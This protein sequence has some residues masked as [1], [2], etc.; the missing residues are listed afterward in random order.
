MSQG[1]SDPAANFSQIY[2]EP[3]FVSTGYN[4]RLDVITNIKLR[5]EVLAGQSS[6][7]DFIWAEIGGWNYDTEQNNLTYVH[8][9]LKR[10]L[11]VSP[12]NPQLPVLLFQGPLGW[13]FNAGDYKITITAERAVGKTPLQSI[14]TATFAEDALNVVNDS[15]GDLFRSFPIT[16]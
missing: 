12:S 5:A 16:P 9:S 10:A 4:D 13:N 3:S 8:L 15:K 7:A 6:S 11:L 2:L 14:V 1:S